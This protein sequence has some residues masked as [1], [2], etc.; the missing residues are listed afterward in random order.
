MSGNAGDLK[1]VKPLFEQAAGRFMPQVVPAKVGKSVFSL[2]DAL[3][4]EYGSI[5]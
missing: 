2:H 3:P 5:T 4:N 1:R